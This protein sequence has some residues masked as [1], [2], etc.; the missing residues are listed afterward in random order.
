MLRRGYSGRQVEG[1]A[2]VAALLAMQLGGGPGAG[3]ILLGAVSDKPAA[4]V[5]AACCIR[6]GCL[7]KCLR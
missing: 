5:D 6:L 7:G 4:E 1:S 3:W 2:G